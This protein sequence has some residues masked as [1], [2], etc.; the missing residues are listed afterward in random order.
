MSEWECVACGGFFKSYAQDAECPYCKSTWLEEVG[1][2]RP[3]PD[4]G[5]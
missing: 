2:R 4:D 3:R 5:D 1:V